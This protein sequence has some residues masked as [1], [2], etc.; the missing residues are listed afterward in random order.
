MER[1]LFSE[2]QFLNWD[3]ID[4]WKSFIIDIIQYDQHQQIS[5]N[6]NRRSQIIKPHNTGLS[7]KL[8]KYSIKPI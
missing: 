1:Y 6:G 8:N 2:L 3:G 4:K 7:R 5:S